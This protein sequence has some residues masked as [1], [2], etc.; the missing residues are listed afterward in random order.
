ML[1]ATYQSKKSIKISWNAKTL[2]FIGET[3]QHSPLQKHIF[4]TCPCWN[5]KKNKPHRKDGGKCL[6]ATKRAL[7]SSPAQQCH[8]REICAFP[9]LEAPSEGHL[10]QNL[11]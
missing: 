11:S 10:P 2:A 1:M 9:N 4:E 5:K 6:G 7:S 3:S 8:S